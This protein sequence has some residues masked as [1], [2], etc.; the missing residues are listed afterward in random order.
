MEGPSLPS[1]A[2]TSG[3][4]GENVIGVYTFSK[5]FCPGMR[6]GFNIGPKDVIAKMANIK[7]GNTLNSPKYNQDM[8]TAFLTQMDVDGYIERCRAF[9]REKLECF[10]A[11]WRNPFPM[12]Q[13]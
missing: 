3:R 13:A 1:S 10:S 11:I 5:L 6:I 2:W 9:Y 4:G 12:I 7:E 8:R